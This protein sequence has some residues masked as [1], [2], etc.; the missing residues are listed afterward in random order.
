MA[1]L[2]LSTNANEVVTITFKEQTA[3]VN[4]IFRDVDKLAPNDNAIQQ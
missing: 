2:S 3:R 1:V 4:V